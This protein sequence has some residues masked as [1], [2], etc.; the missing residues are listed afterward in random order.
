[1]EQLKMQKWM[2]KVRKREVDDQEYDNVVLAQA[3]ADRRSIK[4]FFEGRRISEQQENQRKKQLFDG[5]YVAAD[6]DRMR[7]EQLRAVDLDQM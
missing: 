3:Q 5:Y 2:E 4:A 1:M 7:K 6:E